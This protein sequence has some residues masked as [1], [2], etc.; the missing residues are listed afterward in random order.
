MKPYSQAFLRY[1]ELSQTHLDFVVV[2]CHAVPALRADLALPDAELSFPPDHFIKARSQKNWVASRVGFYTEELA[3]ST[4]LTVFSYFE[5]YVGDVLREIVDF[6][7]GKTKLQERARVRSRRFFGPLKPSQLT[8]KRKLQDNPDP[9]K[10]AKYEKF[11]RLLDAEGYRFPTDL[12]SNLGTRYLLEKLDK[13]N[14][15]RAWEIPNL[16]QDGL[17]MEV[18]GKDLANFEQARI[19]RNRLAH[20]KPH[21][22]QLA[23]SLR[24]ASELHSFA[25]K[26]DKHICEYF[27]VVQID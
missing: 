15:L 3:R 1:R 21:A 4:V 6:H 18:E 8:Y 9:K 19:T 10:F 11:A 13:R 27:F 24:Y 26:I 25:A 7:G 23:T 22:L 16:V 14:G 20:G 17:L 12:L 2:V 5:S